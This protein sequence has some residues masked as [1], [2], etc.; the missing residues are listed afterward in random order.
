MKRE[1]FMTDVY[2]ITL[3]ADQQALADLIAVG[4][5]K[6]ATVQQIMCVTDP[7]PDTYE[8]TKK[9][10]VQRRPH[11]I[12]HKIPPVGTA[13]PKPPH[14]TSE[15]VYNVLTQHFAPKQTFKVAELTEK[16][17]AQIQS[18]YQGYSRDR[19]SAHISRFYEMDLIKRVSGSIFEGYA[20]QYEKVITPGE[21]RGAMAEYNQQHKAKKR[22]KKAQRENGWFNNAITGS[23]RL[24]S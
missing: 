3:L 22:I 10:P 6:G 7:R 21:L 11:E 12:T 24:G 17:N 15:L 9:L 8:A 19:V 2:K 5:K 18:K 4:L 13:R 1:I 23:R 20:Y 14:L 16:I